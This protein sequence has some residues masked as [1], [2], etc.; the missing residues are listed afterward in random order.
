[1][2]TYLIAASKSQLT[3]RSI[4]DKDF[5]IVW[6]L[7][8]IWGL[9]KSPANFTTNHLSGGGGGRGVECWGRVASQWPYLFMAVIYLQFP[10]LF[11]PY[12]V[13]KCE[14]KY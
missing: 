9:Y 13:S 12:D 10:S 14:I 11:S 8:K 7:G 4:G 6:F 5:H 2:C 3:Y 1:M